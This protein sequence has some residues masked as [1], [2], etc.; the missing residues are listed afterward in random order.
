MGKFR[1]EVIG[2]AEKHIKQ[3]IKSGNKKNINTIE[4]ILVEL[5]ENPFKGTGNPEPLKYELSGFWSRRINA[6][7][8]LIY[9]IEEEIVTVCVV[10][11]M[12]HYSDK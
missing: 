7:D 2:I 10:S 12:G 11:T 1:V 9:F 4:K 3:H 8:R 6:K 5:S